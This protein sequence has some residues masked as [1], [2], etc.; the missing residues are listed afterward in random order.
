M[1]GLLDLGGVWLARAYALYGMAFLAPATCFFL[2][3]GLLGVAVWAVVSHYRGHEPWP[4]VR[5]ILRRWAR[6]VVEIAFGLLNPVLYLAIVTPSLPE[7]RPTA[8]WWLGF[9]RSA[10]AFW[11]SSG[12]VRK[13]SAM[14]RCSSFTTSGLRA[15]TS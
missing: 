3:F 6:L 14:R 13:A 12:K 5:A 7:L 9:I 1:E 15:A 10:F 8:G 11:I 4:R 2:N